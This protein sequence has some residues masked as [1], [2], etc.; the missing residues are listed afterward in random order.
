[1]NAKQHGN[2]LH[3]ITAVDLNQAVVRMTSFH[4]LSK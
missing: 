1:V 4:G 2:L 3:C